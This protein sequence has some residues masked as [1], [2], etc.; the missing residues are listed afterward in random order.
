MNVGQNTQNPQI[1]KKIHTKYD[2]YYMTA[3][4]MQ[5]SREKNIYLHIYLSS[6][7]TYNIY[8]CACVHMCV[9]VSSEYY[10]FILFIR[11]FLKILWSWN[12]KINTTVMLIVLVLCLKNCNRSNTSNIH[13]FKWYL[14]LSR[15]G[16]V[17]IYLLVF[18]FISKN[19]IY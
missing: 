15:G 6:T 2:L 7:D 14:Y 10:I 5:Q 9:Y 19:D 3:S 8:A 16:L 1:F 4:W 12:F 11:Y 18:Y 13:I 17:G